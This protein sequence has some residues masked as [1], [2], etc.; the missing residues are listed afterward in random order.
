M[1]GKHEQLIDRRDMETNVVTAGPT[2]T[3]SKDYA[4][5]LKGMG[6]EYTAV[7]E[8]Y[9]RV[10]EPKKVQGWILHLSVIKTQ[11]QRLMEVVLPMLVKE[12]VSFKIVKDY[13]AAKYS[14]DGLL[15]YH[16]LGKIITIY[17]ED[18]QTLITFSRMLIEITE[19]FKGP[20]I[21]TDAN[22]GGIVYTR[23]GG[24]S[25]VLLVDNK[26]CI[27]RYIYD[28]KGELETDSYV[29]PFIMPSSASWPFDEI[30]ALPDEKIKRILY[31]NYLVTTLLKQDVKGDVYKAL[32]V[33]RFYPEWCIIKE[34]KRHMWSDENGRDIR[35]RLR[36][37][38]NLQKDLYGHV[39][40]PEPFEFFEEKDG[41]YI[42][43]QYIKGNSLSETTQN[44]HDGKSWQQLTKNQ[45]LTILDYLLQIIDQC[46]K[47]HHQ[48]Y[49]H[50]DLAPS[51][52][53]IN[54]NNTLVMID[55][56]LTYSL[57]GRTPNPP[58]RLGTPGFM[59]PEQ[60]T[61]TTPTEKEDLYALGGTAIE[62][63]TSIHPIKFGIYN[64]KELI[65]NIFFFVRN[66]QI[67]RLIAQCMNT[68]PRER[69]A[70]SMVRNDV[71]RF[72]Q[73]LTAE[74]ISN[75]PGFNSKPDNQHIQNVITE[76]LNS[77]CT[78]LLNSPIRIKYKDIEGDPAY[79][80]NP[81]LGWYNGVAGV[82]YVLA[83]V[84][85]VTPVEDAEQAY[86]HGLVYVR[87]KLIKEHQAQSLGLYTGN[88]GI[89]MSITAGLERRW[90]RDKSWLDF[91]SQETSSEMLTTQLDL[92]HG[93]A[94]QGLAVLRLLLH[95]PGE[96]KATKLLQQ[97]VDKLLSSQ[98]KDGNWST[99]GNE[100][101]SRVGF[102]TGVTGILFF[103]LEYHFSFPG[104]YRVL[105]AIQRGLHWL[106]DP[107]KTVGNYKWLLRNK[108]KMINIGIEGDIAG[109]ALCFINAFKMTKDSSYK[110]VAEDM[111]RNIP[112]HLVNNEL[113]M[114]NGLSGLGEVY[115]QAR[116]ILKNEEW[117]ERADWI[118]NLLLRT[119][120][121]E[122][123][124][125]RYWVVS[126]PIPASAD[127]M[128]GTG[129]ILHFLSRYNSTGE[130]TFI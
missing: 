91:E 99:D 42:A 21:P 24:M 70:L 48:G 16:Q 117:S 22:L 105:D 90:I 119:S 54:K 109:I 33:K 127:L 17:H 76:S 64:S 12:K 6:L 125:K 94:G 78:M 41:S 52:F 103:L 3:Y 58:F 82:L 14:L 56:E 57:K 113:S 86:L 19:E 39:S 93:V 61:T 20:A 122:K 83:K 62:L 110:I 63:L 80:T 27:G 115:L 121:L 128:T 4:E 47:L 13:K 116:N 60:I 114:A 1:Q 123:Q 97:Y 32:R 34:G 106:R 67:A 8:H 43:M 35:D 18:D 29:I 36:W 28:K 118:A 102:S 79:D 112:H 88:S 72:R 107:A 104:D 101:V 85:Q 23:Y 44:I 120:Y 55:M 30:T 92:A 51:N 98:Q 45:K 130:L 75:V 15:G 59:S 49:V 74:K 5:M 87:E 53:I 66:E 50:R 81:S 26:G 84:S 11:V 89:I 69:P 108:Y 25:P 68:D 96:K 124:D 73:E 37:Q 46:E 38:Y 31:N 65:Q 126:N 111:L 10:G 129:G 100:K 40:V 7:D 2:L 95:F 77:I 9:L 71:K